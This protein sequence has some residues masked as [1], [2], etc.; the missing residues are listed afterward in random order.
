MV[1]SVASTVCYPH[2]EAAVV[3]DKGSLE[4]IWQPQSV[5]SFQLELINSLPEA[6]IQ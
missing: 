6:L 1:T 2:S 5:E 3:C 4:S